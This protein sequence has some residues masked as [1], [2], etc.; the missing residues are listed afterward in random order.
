MTLLGKVA[1]YLPKWLQRSLP[2]VDI[3]GE[4]LLRQLETDAEPVKEPV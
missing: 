1:W 3:E 4:Q 2:N